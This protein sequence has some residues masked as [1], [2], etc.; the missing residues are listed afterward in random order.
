MGFQL[1]VVQGRS[2]TQTLKI[3][4]GVM[5]VGRQQDCQ[6]R[7]ASSQVSR[8]H[9]QIFEKKGL[10]LVKDL[11]SANGTLVNGKKIADQRV[12]E[13]GDELTVG[14]VKFRIERMEDTVLIPGNSVQPASPK[15][16][17][18]AIAG[19]IGGDEDLIELHDIEEPTHAAR[20]VP[21]AKKAAGTQATVKATPVSASDDATIEIGEDAV[22]DYL[23]NIELDDEDKI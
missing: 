13:P 8:K 18:T 12:L 7:I 15:P 1:V 14:S 6:L 3:G 5:T 2:A 17:D 20:A 23:L 19:A 16:G 21:A 22:A 9:C 10:L 11:G 4:S